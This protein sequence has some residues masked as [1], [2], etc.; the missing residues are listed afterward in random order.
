MEQQ[1]N[2]HRVFTCSRCSTVFA[3]GK[4][5]EPSPE[6][7]PVSTKLPIKNSRTFDLYKEVCETGVIYLGLKV[8]HYCEGKFAGKNGEGVL[9][10]IRKVVRAHENTVEA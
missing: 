2:Y 6:I 5:L 4:K 3:N 1:A 9:V 8:F 10:G 7:K